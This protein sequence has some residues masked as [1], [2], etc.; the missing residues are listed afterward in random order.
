LLARSKYRFADTL[1]MAFLTNAIFRRENSANGPFPFSYSAVNKILC[2][3]AV[4]A[5]TIAVVMYATPSKQGRAFQITGK[6]KGTGV[7]GAL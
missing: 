4:D 3:P 1:A 2:G 5:A 7:N 6:K